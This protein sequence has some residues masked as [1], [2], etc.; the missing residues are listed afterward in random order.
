M[1]NSEDRNTEEN[2]DT[3][4]N[5]RSRQARAGNERGSP[6]VAQEAATNE[7]PTGESYKQRKTENN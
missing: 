1:K 7:A 6:V 4:R 3:L 2:H 5:R